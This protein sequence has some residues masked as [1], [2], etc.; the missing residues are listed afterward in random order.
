[1]RSP[2]TTTKKIIDTVRQMYGEGA[3]YN[4]IAD[5]IGGTKNQVAGL[6]HRNCQDIVF[7]GKSA[8]Q[9]GPKET[10]ASRIER[11]RVAL[12]QSVTYRGIADLTGIDHRVVTRIL[13]SDLAD[14]HRQKV[15][16]F[17]AAPRRAPTAVS[18]TRHGPRP[19]PSPVTLICSNP[20]PF[21]AASGCRYP[22][23]S[24]GVDIT[25][26]RVCGASCKT[27]RS[28]CPGHHA[29]SYR[30]VERRAA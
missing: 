1:M 16:D 11:V 25:E 28:F 26:K 30:A 24:E 18:T 20:Q 7:T 17:Q 9:K 21:I 10:D 5:A 27:G 23:W 13:K 3:S 22:L 14:L 4:E 12:D 6:V 2:V 19:I 15:R 8:R 29:L